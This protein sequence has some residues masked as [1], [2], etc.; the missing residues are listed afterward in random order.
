M[1]FLKHVFKKNIFVASL[2]YRANSR[3]ARATER[4]PV[5]EK[6][7]KTPKTKIEATTA[8][9]PKQDKNEKSHYYQWYQHNL[10]VSD[11][12]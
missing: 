6:P 2:V 11:T 4:N 7:E 5:C 8:T 9:P 12:I 3:K 1:W 10:V